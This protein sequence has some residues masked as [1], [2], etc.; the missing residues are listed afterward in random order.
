MSGLVLY[1][2]AVDFLGLYALFSQFRPRD[3]LQEIC[4]LFFHRLCI[5]KRD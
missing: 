5:H 3:V 4:L 2:V 1:D